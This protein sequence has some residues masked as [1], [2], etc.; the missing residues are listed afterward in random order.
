MLVPWNLTNTVYATAHLGSITMMC[1]LLTSCS[2]EKIFLFVLGT[3]VVLLSSWRVLTTQ[4][5]FRLR[6]RTFAVF[7]GFPSALLEVILDVSLC[8]ECGFALFLSGKPCRGTRF[9]CLTPAMPPVGQY[10]RMLMLALPLSKK[11]IS[12]I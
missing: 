8:S 12:C 7:F 5:S 10:F 6:D 4:S 1:I 3:L 11:L 9:R 2:F